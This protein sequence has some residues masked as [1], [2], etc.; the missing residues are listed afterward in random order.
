MTNRYTDEDAAYGAALKLILDVLINANAASANDL[1][2]AFATMREKFLAKEN[3]KGAAI[4]ETFR[5]FCVDPQREKHRE[6]AKQVQRDPPAG[7]A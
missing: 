5:S 3:V 7:S 1:A 6:L 2:S 4:M